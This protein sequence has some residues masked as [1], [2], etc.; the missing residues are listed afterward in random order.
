MPARESLTSAQRKRLRGLAH[1]LKPLVRLGKAGLTAAA[2]AQIDKE[3]ADH[4]LVKVRLPS[5]ADLV[6]KVPKRELVAEIERDARC[7]SAG[8][9]GLIAIL[10]RPHADPKK[11]EIDPGK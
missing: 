4:E 6:G 7:G 2:L 11:R 1:D 10:Y 9:V 5:G 3:L 8:V